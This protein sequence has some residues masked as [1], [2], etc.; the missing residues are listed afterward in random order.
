MSVQEYISSD[1]RFQLLKKLKD[2]RET[3]HVL[4]VA[5][6][7]QLAVCV[8]STDLIQLCW[9]YVG[10][11]LSMPQG[12]RCRRAYFAN[13]FDVIF[14]PWITGLCCESRC[15]QLLLHNS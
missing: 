2:E 11:P 15:I 10:R 5:L 3:P 12:A 1:P 9:E 8:S 6:L 7:D 13:Y 4:D 14:T